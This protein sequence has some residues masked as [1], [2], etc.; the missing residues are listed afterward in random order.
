M[1]TPDDEPAADAALASVAVFSNSYRNVHLAAGATGFRSHGLRYRAPDHVTPA[2]IGEEFLAGTRLV[3]SDRE[4][5]VSVQAY[6]RPDGVVLLSLAGQEGNEDA[7][8]TM[9]LP[10]GVPLRLELGEAIRRRRSSRHFTGDSLGLVELASVVR[11]AAGVTARAKVQVP[12]DGEA[13]L[14][15]RAVAS[16]G[17]LFPVDL[18][19]VALRIRRL[20]GGVYRYDPHVDQLIRTHEPHELPPLLD[21]FAIF[22]D[23]L[24]LRRA[25]AIF[26]LVGHPWRSMRKYGSRGVR[27]LFLEAGAIAQNIHLATMGVGFGS[28]DCASVYDDEVHDA[29]GI[30]G[31]FQTLLHT[32]IVGAPTD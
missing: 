30:D 18:H 20:E 27:F 12:G 6:F 5:E 17:G 31:R 29:L 11:S 2:Q 16:G 24:T 10:N 22:E 19:V 7:I 1:N 26:L 14:A 9:P 28:V 21:S 8:D 25:A 23:A 3:R 32:V 13:T 15:F 4:T